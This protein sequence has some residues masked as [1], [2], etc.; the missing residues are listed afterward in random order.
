MSLSITEE[1]LSFKPGTRARALFYLKTGVLE[2][3]ANV[4]MQA[5]LD[6]WVQRIERHGPTARERV[7]RKLG[8]GS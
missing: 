7:L 1:F 4:E 2:G 3:N 8:E 5:R 6:R